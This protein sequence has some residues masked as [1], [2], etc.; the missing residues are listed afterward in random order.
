MILDRRFFTILILA[1]I[2]LFGSIGSHSNVYSADKSKNLPPRGVSVTPEYTGIIIPQGDDINLDLEVKNLGRQGEDIVVS[3]TSIPRG[4]K[5]WTSTYSFSVNGI[6][7]DSDSSKTLTFK[8]EPDKSIEPGEYIFGIQGRT[9]DKK[10]ISKSRLF[11][12]V[13]EK[14][15]EKKAKGVNITSSYPV[16]QG[17]SDAKFEFS[18][19]VE[20]KV[21]KDTIYNLTAQGPKD[22]D[23]NFKPAYEDKF[24]SSLRIK[25]NQN[26]SMAIEVKPDMRAQAGQYPVKVTVSS[27]KA[28]TE[29]DLMVVLTGTYNIDA[30][31]RDGLLSLT[32]FQGKPANLSFY[33]KNIG[34]ARQTQVNFLSFKPESW[35]VEFKPERLE[36]LEPDDLKQVE[37]LIT[38]AENALVGDYS[39]GINIEGEKA[40]KILELRTTVKASTVW[41]WIGIGIIVLVVLGLVVLF[42]RMGRR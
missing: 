8:A 11:V 38:P 27:E 21:N 25:A 18:I 7:V 42:I 6:H 9:R 17:P 22:W 40:S 3:I 16:L 19:E 28:K 31:T 39:V 29:V 1:V 30:G 4:W 34:S 10:Y 32:A 26:E 20:N 35:K 5:A 15:K 12:T 33:V 36:M 41:G 14:L 37:V 2:F 23:I 13:E 24:I